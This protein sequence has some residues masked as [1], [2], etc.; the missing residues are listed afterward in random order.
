M[1]C[2]PGWRIVGVAES[3]LFQGFHLLCSWRHWLNSM[4]SALGLVWIGSMGGGRCFFEGHR[5]GRQFDVC[6]VGAKL[7]D[8]A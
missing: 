7:G 4:T 3:A 2:K 1:V 5:V 8:G 6:A